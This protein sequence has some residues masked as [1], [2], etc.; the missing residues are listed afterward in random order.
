MAESRSQEEWRHTSSVLALIA[1][2]N[3]DPKKTPPF[4]PR[5]FD[6]HSQR[7]VGSIIS[8]LRS[9]CQRKGEQNA[10]H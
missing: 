4:R 8:E 3:R 7:P 10:G 1:N 9:V 2:V 5:D 6:P